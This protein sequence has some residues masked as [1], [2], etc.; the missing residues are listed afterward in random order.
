VRV[1][2]DPAKVE[3]NLRKHGV[4]FEDAQ[5]VFDDPF[6]K[7]S[8]DP[9]RS[10]GERRMVG[11]GEDLQRRILFVWFAV[12]DD[13]PHLIGAREPTRAERRRYVRGDELRDEPPLDEMPAEVDFTPAFRGLQN[14]RVRAWL[15]PDVWRAFPTDEQVNAALRSLIAEGKA[16]V[17]TKK[18]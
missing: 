6:F 1:T 15:D 11:M 16:P 4:A 9:Y 7:A 2:W 3:E 18:R 13:V 14:L 5:H 17:A 12:R 10:I 8:D